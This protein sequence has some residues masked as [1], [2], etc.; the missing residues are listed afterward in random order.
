MRQ[1]NWLNHPA[2]KNID[3]RKKEIIL[4]LIQE[5]AGKPLAQSAPILMKA[6][7]QLKS[8]GLTFTRAENDL[9]ISV[10][11]DG[12]SPSEKQQFNMVKQILMGH[13]GR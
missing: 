2:L 8:Q 10:L 9:I 11:T 1:E 6:N 5:S 7:Q 3:P 12:M 13:L 4:T